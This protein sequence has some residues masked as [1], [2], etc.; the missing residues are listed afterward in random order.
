M[1]NI[2]RFHPQRSFSCVDDVIQAEFLLPQPFDLAVVYF[3]AVG[4]VQV[5]QPPGT[6]FVPDAPV[7]ARHFLVRGEIQTN[8]KFGFRSAKYEFFF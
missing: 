4:T 5:L 1:P 7:Q 3:R 6:A 2:E 8:G